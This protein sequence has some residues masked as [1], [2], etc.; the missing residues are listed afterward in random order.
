M[1]HKIERVNQYDDI[2]FSIEVL[3]EHGAFLIDDKYKCSFKIMNE[4]TTIVEFD[5]EVN[6]D[7]VI[8]EF[9]FYAEHITKFYDTNN[10]LI[11]SFED[12]NIFKV[13][14]EDIQPSQFYVDKNK[15][16]AVSHFIKNEDDIIIPLAKINDEL[17]SIDGHT[18]L[19]VAIKRD[20]KQVYG[21]YTLTEDYI[22]DFVIE[23]KKRNVL[24]PYDLKI[25]THDEYKIKWD[26]FCNDLFSNQITK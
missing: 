9:R 14:I 7:K 19:Y 20:Y 8:D 22:S 4:N 11:K 5:K 24:T 21:F 12:I 25:L 26:E 15:V 3:L 23:A 16:E 1:P 17:V 18:R 13:N 10:K 2:R 6:V